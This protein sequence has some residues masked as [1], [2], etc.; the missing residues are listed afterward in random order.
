MNEDLN[1]ILKIK[2]PIKD[3]HN[4]YIVVDDINQF[5][6]LNA[7]HDTRNPK[8]IYLYKK[9]DEKYIIK[10]QGAIQ[11]YCE[12]VSPEKTIIDINLP[13]D[14]NFHKDDHK[15][16]LNFINIL[17]NDLQKK[18]PNTFIELPFD[19]ITFNFQTMSCKFVKDYD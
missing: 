2:N 6:E 13:K 12:Y 8:I 9:I 3:V 10:T 5:L 17:K 16:I 14:S 19:K 18:L 7:N 4:P 1:Y 15:H 11:C